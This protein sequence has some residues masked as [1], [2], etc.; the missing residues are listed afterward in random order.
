MKQIKQVLVRGL[1]WRELEEIMDDKFTISLG[2][3]FNVDFPMS[4]LEKVRINGVTFTKKF[5]EE[6]A[7]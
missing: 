3:T 6:E 7:R 4:D 5:Q 2:N 1:G